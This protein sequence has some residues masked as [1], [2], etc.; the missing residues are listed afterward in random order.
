MQ[1]KSQKAFEQGR[2]AALSG[3][4]VNVCPYITA[5]YQHFR[6]WWH[7][8]YQAGAKHPD[9]VSQTQATETTN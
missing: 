1:S 7:L 5:R 2:A 8:G 4:A 3:N 6:N 9:P